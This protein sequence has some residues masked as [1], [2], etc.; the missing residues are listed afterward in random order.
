MKIDAMPQQ[1]TQ[2]PYHNRR[3]P[4]PIWAQGETP[5]RAQVVKWIGET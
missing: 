3:W 4:N 5:N 2:L 1:D